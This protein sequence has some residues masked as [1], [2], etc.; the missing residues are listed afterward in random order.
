M[1]RKAMG[2]ATLTITI[3]NYVTNGTELIEVSQKAT[4]LSANSESRPLDWSEN[5]KDGLFGPVKAQ[6][7]RVS[8]DELE[9]EFLKSGWTTDATLHGVIQTRTTSMGDKE[10]V[11]DQVSFCARDVVN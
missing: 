3:K 10:W 4:G 7:R 6:A 2:A 5:P 11:I 1:K 9:H 8:L